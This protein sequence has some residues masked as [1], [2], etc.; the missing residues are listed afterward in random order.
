M[1]GFIETERNMGLMLM[2]IAVQFVING[3]ETIFNR[4]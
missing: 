3:A 1:P 4:L 2:G